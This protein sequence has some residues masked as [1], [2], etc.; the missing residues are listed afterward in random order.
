[1]RKG[2][3]ELSV[4]AYVSRKEAYGYEILTEMRDFSGL[5]FKESTLYL[6]LARLTKNGMLSVRVAPSHSGPPRRYYKLTSKGRSQLQ[7]MTVF[8]RSLRA[9]IDTL[10][11]PHAR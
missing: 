2:L 9:D 6:V 3:A 4:L 5:S 7:K 8:W 1:M 11:P 10:V